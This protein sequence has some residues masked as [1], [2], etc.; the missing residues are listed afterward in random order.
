MHIATLS[1]PLTRPSQATRAQMDSDVHMGSPPKRRRIDLSAQNTVYTSTINPLDPPVTRLT[2][3]PFSSPTHFVAALPPLPDPVSSLH[4][5]IQSI[6]SEEEDTLEDMRG[7]RVNGAADLLGIED[8]SDSQWHEAEVIREKRVESRSSEQGASSSARNSES[9]Y[10]R[11]FER[12]CQSHPACH[13]RALTSS[14]TSL[15]RLLRR[16]LRLLARHPPQ[17]PSR[18][19][20]NGP[21]VLSVRRSVRSS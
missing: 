20:S 8:I 19:R 12:L 21:P 17:S 9:P 10:A 18:S 14:S 2:D 13:H 15:I 4:E 11:L 16:R 5:S 1:K 6:H 7:S 3:L